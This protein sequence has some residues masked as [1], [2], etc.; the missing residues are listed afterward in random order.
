[1]PVLVRHCKHVLADMYNCLSCKLCARSAYVVRVQARIPRSNILYVYICIYIYIYRERE[2]DVHIACVYTC[3]YIYIYIERERC[4][5]VC[6]YIYIHIGKYMCIYIYI[7]IHTHIY[8]TQMRPSICRGVFYP[9]NMSM[10]VTNSHTSHY[11]YCT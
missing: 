9:Q 8:N 6:I 11:Y 10:V 3:A 7:C 2:K 4:L 1:M 5:Y